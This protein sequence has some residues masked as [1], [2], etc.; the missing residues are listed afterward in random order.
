M[1]PSVPTASIIA[2]LGIVFSYVF[3]RL[4]LRNKDLIGLGEALLKKEE[5]RLKS[6]VN[7][8]EIEI[9]EISESDDLKRKLRP[10]SY[11]Q[12]RKFIFIFMIG[13][14]SLGAAVPQF[15]PDFVSMFSA[16][17]PQQT[18]GTSGGGGSKT[19]VRAKERN[20]GQA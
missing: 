6:K 2:I 15:S 18:Q 19:C 8:D 16:K 11:G 17:K 20:K 5:A 7:Y 3:L 1:S 10:N 14:F 13:L 9:M 4:D 12:A